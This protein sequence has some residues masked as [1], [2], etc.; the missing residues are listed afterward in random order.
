[1]EKRILLATDASEFSSGAEREAV[2]YA[3]TNGGKLFCML[4]MEFKPEF[5]ALAPQLLEE[6]EK[7]AIKHLEN[8][9]KM[10]KKENV[11][12]EVI[13]REGQE[14]YKVIIEEADKQKVDLIV[15][16][17]RGRTGLMRLLV[18]SVTAKVIGHFKGQVLVVQREAAVNW[19]N[20]LVATDG[21]EYG[22]AAVNEA[23]KHAKKYGGELKIVHAINVIADFQEESPVF[24]PQLIDDITKRVRSELEALKVRAEKEGVSAEI[25]VKEDEPYRAIVDLAEELN[26]D[27]IILGSHGR[28]GMRRLLMGSVTE[29]VIGHANCA[30]LVVK[31]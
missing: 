18:G 19:K 17:R 25:F 11:A 3:K 7:D 30:V 24:I 20:I 31:I 12:C 27:I 26:S 2:K 10:A 21:S 22:N 13:L 5:L 16:G 9:K 8:L 28:T 23:L 29:R 14:P 1:M 15:M 4:V 6:S